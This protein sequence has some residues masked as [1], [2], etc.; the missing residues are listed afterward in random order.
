MKKIVFFLMSLVVAG[1]N[2]LEQNPSDKLFESNA[3]QTE[4]DLKLY[5]NGFY[6][7][8]PSAYTI[9]YGDRVSDY[10]APIAVGKFFLGSYT[11]QD[12]G[13]ACAT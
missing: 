4:A 8:L 2:T 6:S 5:T 13:G 9:F 1:C 10:M 7:M 3:F 11:A 12:S